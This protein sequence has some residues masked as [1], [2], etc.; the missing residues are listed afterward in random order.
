MKYT[1]KSKWL[2]WDG[3]KQM[4]NQQVELTDEQKEHLEKAGVKLIKEKGKKDEVSG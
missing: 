3:L 2:G 4:E 1:V